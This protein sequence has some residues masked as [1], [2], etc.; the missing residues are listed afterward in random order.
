LHSEE[1]YINNENWSLTIY[2]PELVPGTYEVVATTTR[3]SN[4]KTSTD[5]TNSELV[6]LDTADPTT[7]TSANDGGLES[8][9]DLASLIANRNFNKKTNSFVNKK[10]AQKKFTPNSILLKQ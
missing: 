2:Y 4:N 10:E 8:N 3:T 1:I 5:A 6:I 7:V 9:G